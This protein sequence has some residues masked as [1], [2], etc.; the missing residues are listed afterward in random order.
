M[1]W[2]R[3]KAYVEKVVEAIVGARLDYLAR[4]PARVDKQADDGTL[5]LTPDDKRIPPITNV[6]IHVGVPGTTVEVEQ[7]SRVLLAYA[8]GDPSKPIAEIWEPGASV[9]KV[10]MKATTAVIDADSIELG[11]DAVLGVA[12]LTDS[13]LA[14]PFVGVITGASAKAKAL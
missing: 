10:T 14:G 5:E 7:G 8:G 9:T 6:K 12:R 2:D 11:K 13:V 1:S 4:Y 3:F